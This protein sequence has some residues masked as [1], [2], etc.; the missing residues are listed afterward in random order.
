MNDQF[1]YREV[2]LLDNTHIKFFTNNSL[3]EMV[4]DC[5]YKVVMRR[6]LKNAVDC[7]E[8]AGAYNLVPDHVAEF[9]KSRVYGEVYQFVWELKAI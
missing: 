8:F 6:N 2:G 1:T 9:L 7:S 5:G 4:E 3:Q